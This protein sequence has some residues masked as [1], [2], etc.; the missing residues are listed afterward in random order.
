MTYG[1]GGDMSSGILLVETRPNSPEDAAAYHHWYD[2]VH[3]PEILKVDGFVSARR[4]EAIDGS[5]FIAIYEIDI[6]VETAK[7]NLAAV[8]ATGVMSAPEGVQ[9]NPPP[10]VRY[11]TQIGAFGG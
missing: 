4:L 7:A 8:T 10:V 5:S 3:V 2:E 11:F 9:L 1:A 6:D